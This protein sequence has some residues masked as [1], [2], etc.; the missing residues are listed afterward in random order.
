[1]AAGL[2][3]FGAVMT[4]CDE[5]YAQP[6]VIEPEGGIG[7]GAWDSP[8]T[9]Y[10]CLIGSVNDKLAEE[11]GSDEVWVSGYIVGVVNTEVGTVI[12]ERSAQFE[13]P[14]DVNTNLLIA[15]APDE[16]NWENCA[17]VQLPSGNVRTALN[18]TDH[19]ENLGELVTI[20]G[21]TGVK[22]CG[23]Y[24]LK[25][26]SD[27]N[28]GDKGKEPVVL[29]SVDGPFFE[30]FSST[31]DFSTYAAQGW[32]SVVVTSS[33]SGW[34]IRSYD[35]NN[36]VTTSAYLGTANGGPY[37]FWLLTPEIDM[38][39]LTEKTVQFETQA[40]YATEN[41]DDCTLEVY[42]LDSDN[43]ATA[44]KTKLDAT[45]AVPSGSSYTD[46][47]DSG[48]I[49]LSSFTGVVRIGWRY[50]S[51]QGGNGNSATYCVD[52]VNVGN[53]KE[54][55]PSTPD[56]PGVGGDVI[57]ETLNAGSATCDWTFDNVTLPSGYSS[58]WKWT[59]RD[60]AHYLNGSAHSNSDPQPESEAFAISPVISLV[61]V[62][63]AT[64][65]FEHAAKFQT[66]IRTLC[67]FMVREKSAS[68]WTEVAI[69]N[70][71]VAGQP[72]T[73][74]NSGSLDISAFDGKEIQLA[75]KYQSDASGADTWEIR[76]LK[77]T[78]VK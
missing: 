72:W 57:C 47:I 16:T 48:K 71:Q 63:K 10:Q 61:G 53:A 36:Y 68:E 77:I 37:E 70:W 62:T 26:C 13:G 75:F 33:L 1:M 58:I 54:P 52:N 31:T 7:T 34:Y 73:F 2:A 64:V 5:D 49:D 27:Y 18:L 21:T 15:M 44:V 46:W 41:P 32:K 25:N 8:M 3:V 51:K 67:K 59:E 28:W 22:Y 69:K 78:G 19:P 65:E 11:T 6:P 55:D 45:V 12:N 43:P 74:V 39:K 76:N 23:A 60:G 30:N 4:S 56:T 17:T 66:N 24:G 35:N 50:W 20:K 42:V 38:S 9:A 40:A 14:F 29:P